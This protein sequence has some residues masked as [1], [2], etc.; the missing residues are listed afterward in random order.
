M[1]MICTNPNCDRCRRGGVI[2]DPGVMYCPDC[3][4]LLSPSPQGAQSGPLG[5]PVP[6]PVDPGKRILACLIDVL[7]AIVIAAVLMPLALI[8]IVGWLLG[9]IEPLFWLFRDIKGASPGKAVLGLRVVSRSGAPASQQQLILRN[10]TLSLGF[11]GYLIP[12]IGAGITAFLAPI[13]GIV[14]IIMLLTSRERLGDRFA[15]T[16]VVHGK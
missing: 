7:I 2:T 13:A 8:P 3:G 10:V 6:T 16:T 14:E 15:N 9:F 12:V 1:A 11:I 4:S 5:S